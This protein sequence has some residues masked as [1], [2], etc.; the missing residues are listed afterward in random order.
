MKNGFDVGKFEQRSGNKEL[1]AKEKKFGELTKITK[2]GMAASQV[3]IKLI[4]HVER[5]PKLLL[6]PRAR[7]P[8]A[9]PPQM[10]MSSAFH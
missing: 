2:Q 5:N 8:F 4:L 1:K 9:R 10:L 6:G 7:S 3:K